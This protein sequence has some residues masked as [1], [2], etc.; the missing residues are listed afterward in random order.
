M[1]LNFGPLRTYITIG[2]TLGV[3]LATPLWQT[4]LAG[5]SMPHDWPEAKPI[6]FDLAMAT[7]H[8]VL[9]MYSWLP[10]AIYHIGFH[11]W[12]FQH[13]LFDGW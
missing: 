2:A 1:A 4:A 7:G 11:D 12:A 3:I 6:L 9:R 10:S 8:G 13:W 5:K